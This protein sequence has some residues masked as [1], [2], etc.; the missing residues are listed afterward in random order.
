MGKIIR[1]VLFGEADTLR[2]DENGMVI[3][4]C[5]LLE[6]K[7]ID[8]ALAELF[9]SAQKEAV[10]LQITDETSSRRLSSERHQ[11]QVDAEEHEIV[12]R[13]VARKAVS[14][15]VDAENEHQVELKKL[16]L[17]YALGD[18]ELART[19]VQTTTR[20]DDELRTASLRAAANVERR[21]KEA[22]ADAAANAVVYEVEE[23]HLAKV[24]ALELER[25]RAVAEAEAVR[26]KAIQPELVGALHAAADADV[27]KTAAANMNLV[28]LLGGKSPQ[29][30][31]EHV[32]RGTPLERSTRDMRA[33][34]EAKNGTIKDGGNAE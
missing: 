21:R 17:R 29:E 24:T 33:R 20:L 32:V 14:Q 15:V 16:E 10:K 8:P 23:A 7:I 27:M 12:R 30:L 6:L 19:S 5:E 28:S 34:S 9:T 13:A 2:F 3:D 18:V 26:L 22:E 11:D 31:F 25:A 1:S 4:A